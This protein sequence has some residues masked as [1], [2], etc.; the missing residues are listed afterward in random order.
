[1]FGSSEVDPINDELENV[2]LDLEEF[3]SPSFSLLTAF[4]ILPDPN[5]LH[6]ILQPV[7]CP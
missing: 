6:N 5:R 4:L 2:E 1:M 7:A 3:L